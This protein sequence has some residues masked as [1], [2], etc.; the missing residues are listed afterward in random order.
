MLS[1][2]SSTLLLLWLGACSASELKLPTFVASHMVLQREPLQSRLW[3]WASPM[4][5]VTATLNDADL[6]VF[7]IADEDGSWW[8]NLPPQPAG[9][10]HTIQISDVTTDITLEDIAFGDVYLCSG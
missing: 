4:A 8:L 6:Q 9:T 5:N 7:T 10:G 1:L 3:G 2:F